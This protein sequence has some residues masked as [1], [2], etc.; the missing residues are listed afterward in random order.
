MSERCPFCNKV[1]EDDNIPEI[2]PGC[3]AYSINF[4]RIEVEEEKEEEFDFTIL[5]DMWDKFIKNIKN[6]F[7]CIY[8][9]LSSM[10]DGIGEFAGVNIFV[11]LVMFISKIFLSTYW[12]DWKILN[13]GLILWGFSIFLALLFSNTLS[14]IS[15]SHRLMNEKIKKFLETEK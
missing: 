15:R 11:S 2:C 5:K 14:K 12:S 6:I 8:I 9:F 1:F 3:N 7:V 13:I 10:F 4:Q